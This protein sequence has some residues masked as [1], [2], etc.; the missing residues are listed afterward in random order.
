MTRKEY[1]HKLDTI[2]EYLLVEIHNS[3]NG[4]VEKD[5]DGSI[6]ISD[7]R[8]QP[9]FEFDSDEVE[10]LKEFATEH[11]IDLSLITD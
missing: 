5:T 11:C 4:K 6:S 7:F 8:Y 9:E 3:M 1:E 2:L 10:V